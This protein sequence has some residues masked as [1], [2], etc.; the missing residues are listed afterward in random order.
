[1]L[2]N[3]S[4]SSYVLTNGEFARS[5]SLAYG[6]IGCILESRAVSNSQTSSVRT[7]LPIGRY[8][9]CWLEATPHV[10]VQPSGASAECTQMHRGTHLSV[11]VSLG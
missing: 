3:A 11:C 10:T 2:C 6:T 5:R 1:M 7:L 9:R 8:L 4:T